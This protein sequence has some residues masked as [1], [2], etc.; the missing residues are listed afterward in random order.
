MVKMSDAAPQGSDAQKRIASQYN[1]AAWE[2]I[3]KSNLSIDECV[4][5]VR[6]AGTAAYHWGVVGTAA[7]IAHAHLLFAWALARAGAAVLAVDSAERALK[8]FTEN[9]SKEW[10]RAFAHAAMAAS[11]H[12]AGDQEGHHQHYKEA[13]QLESKLAPGDLRLFQA[14]FR[15][16]PRP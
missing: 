6:L 5:L 14:A 13:Q 1:N 15:N 9:Q 11:L 2:L 3:E 4:A 7:N 16:V 10:E 12:C 8:Y